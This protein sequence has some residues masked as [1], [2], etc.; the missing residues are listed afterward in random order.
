MGR[1]L[2]QWDCPELARKLKADGIVQ[3]ISPE[4]VGRIL[5]SHK[6]KPWRHH[7][8]LSAKVRRSEHFAKLVHT[9]VELYT[10]PLCKRY[11]KSEP[12]AD[13]KVSH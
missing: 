7:L 1:S 3:T 11:H 9:L 8:W 4:T 6:L 13:P 12:L 5:R 10:R 2:S